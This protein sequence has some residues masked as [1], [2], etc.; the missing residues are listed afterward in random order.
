L[1]TRIVF[2]AIPLFTTNISIHT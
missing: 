2:W 1:L